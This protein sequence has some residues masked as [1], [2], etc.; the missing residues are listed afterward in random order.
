[1][2]GPLNVKMTK[3]TVAYRNFVK[4]PENWTHGEGG[5]FADK[6]LARPGRK[7]HSHYEAHHTS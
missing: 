6:S 1:M 3:L 2:H 4:E 7:Q 5:L